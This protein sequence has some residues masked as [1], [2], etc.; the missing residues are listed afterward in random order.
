M[1]KVKVIT[2]ALAKTFDTKDIW[3]INFTV[4]QCHTSSSSTAVCRHSAM[5][6]EEL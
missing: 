5:S 1:S 2:V 6:S 4:E 3:L